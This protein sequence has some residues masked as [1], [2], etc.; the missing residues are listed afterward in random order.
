[1]KSDD[2]KIVEELKK[3]SVYGVRLLYQKYG[4]RFGSMAENEFGLSHE[5]AI[6]VTTNTLIKIID[7]IDSFTWRSSQSFF[8][9]I[10]TIFKNTVLD[11]IRKNK[12]QEV[13]L[14]YFDVSNFEHD[15]MRRL[16]KTEKAII[17]K[18]KEGFESLGTRKDE[19]MNII[20]QAFKEL[21]EKEQIIFYCYL[22]G[23]Q[24]N[25]I[26]KY[27]GDS[28]ANLKVYTGRIIKKFL[29]SLSKN[30]S[31]NQGELYEKIRRLH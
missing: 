4:N 22:N 16:G 31:I 2:S 8:N 27:A 23:Y 10:R 11:F 3:G 1:M 28:V 17:K 26:S 29:K 24:Y 18:I 14:E 7:R 15:E 6:S 13:S 19:R 25:E 5:D 20:V 30:F 12:K 21:S 9:W